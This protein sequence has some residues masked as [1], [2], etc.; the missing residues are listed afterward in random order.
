MVIEDIDLS[1]PLHEFETYVKERE[2]VDV[3]LQC[4]E[5]FFWFDIKNLIHDA[6]IDPYFYM[7]IHANLTCC[8]L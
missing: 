4:D 3:G 5:Q 1:E 7:G 2:F 8:F 6:I